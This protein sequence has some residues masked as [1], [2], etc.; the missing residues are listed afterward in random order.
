MNKPDFNYSKNDAVL[1][2]RIDRR[3][4]KLT[5]LTYVMLAASVLFFLCSISWPLI[6]LWG[7]KNLADIIGFSVVG[8]AVAGTIHLLVMKTLDFVGPRFFK[9]YE[10][11]VQEDVIRL[12]GSVPVLNAYMAYK[13]LLSIRPNY[14]LV[15]DGIAAKQFNC[16]MAAIP[17]TEAQIEAQKAARERGLSIQTIG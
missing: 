10:I 4:K 1:Q 15:E 17:A 6:S 5:V 12:V 13:D 7:Q 2:E 14:A 11:D 3:A 16:T 8:A 9:S